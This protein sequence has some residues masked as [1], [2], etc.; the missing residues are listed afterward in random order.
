MHMYFRLFYCLFCVLLLFVYSGINFWPSHLCGDSMMAEKTVTEMFEGKPD[1]PV[2]GS[3]QPSGTCIC[4]KV[5][6]Q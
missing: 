4:S 2:D 6:K 3:K 5:T 1:I